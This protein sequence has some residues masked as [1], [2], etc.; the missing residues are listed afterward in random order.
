MLRSH[1]QM[2]KKLQTAKNGSHMHRKVETMFV[3]TDYQMDQYDVI[4]GF[5]KTIS[6]YNL[7]IDMKP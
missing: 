6:N 7:A 5:G 3:I 2:A 1:H 4:C